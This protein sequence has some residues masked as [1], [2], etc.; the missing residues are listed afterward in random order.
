L[1]DSFLSTHPRKHTSEPQYATNR[2][3]YSDEHQATNELWVLWLQ[4]NIF[5]NSM[6]SYQYATHRAQLKNHFMSTWRAEELTQVVEYLPSKYELRFKPKFH[7][8]TSKTV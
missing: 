6:E 8:K 4:G 7:P 2:H 5:R 3:I 1:F